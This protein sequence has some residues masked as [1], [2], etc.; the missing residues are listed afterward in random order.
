MAESKEEVKSTSELNV[1]ENV[2][3]LESIGNKINEIVGSKDY[4]NLFMNE[5]GNL[6]VALQKDS[7]Q[8]EKT[9]KSSYTFEQRSLM[10]SEICALNML[11]SALGNL[12][13]IIN[14]RYRTEIEI[15]A[16]KAAM[17][18]AKEEEKKDE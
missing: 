6:S 4:E 17:E 15:A 14:L 9:G 1:P 5:L 7:E 16:A 3:V 2:R 8:I 12:I 13:N 11:D 18:K 10:S